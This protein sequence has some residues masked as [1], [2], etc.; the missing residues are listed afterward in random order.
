V[1]SDLT[2]NA[3]LRCARLLPGRIFVADLQVPPGDYN[4]TLE[5]VDDLGNLVARQDV[6]GHRVLPGNFN[7]V[8]AVSLR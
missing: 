2:E 8:Q 4:L 3:D 6:E 5:F 1:A 7:L